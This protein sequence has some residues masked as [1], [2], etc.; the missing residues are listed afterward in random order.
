M[1]ILKVVCDVLLCDASLG[2]L[3][4]LESVPGEKKKS[5]GRHKFNSGTVKSSLVDY[6]WSHAAR[7][8]ECWKYIMEQFNYMYV[9]WLCPREWL[10]Y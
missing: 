7:Y 8:V 9:F 5:T 3:F 4:Q 10:D 6:R 1:S 2:K